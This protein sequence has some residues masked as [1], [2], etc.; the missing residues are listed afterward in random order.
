MLNFDHIE[1]AR[2]KGLISGAIYHHALRKA[3]PVVA[4]I[5]PLPLTS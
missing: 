4:I 1:P 5:G 3:I 2:A